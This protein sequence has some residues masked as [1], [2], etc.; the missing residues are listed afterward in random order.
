M[1]SRD[2]EISKYTYVCIYININVLRIRS[3]RALST[4]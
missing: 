3:Q 4:K 2:Y 1:P